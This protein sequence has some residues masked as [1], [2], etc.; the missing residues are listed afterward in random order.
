MII[1][2]S[3]ILH[4]PVSSV[5]NYSPK[6]PCMSLAPTKLNPKLAMASASGTNIPSSFANH[7]G[8]PANFPTLPTGQP[9]KMNDIY[10]AGYPKSGSTWL[11]R[12]VADALDSPAGQPF[13]GFNRD[14][15]A[16][17]KERPG[18]FVVRRGHFI[19]DDE[20]PAAVYKNV[21][22]NSNEA[23]DHKFI[24]IIRDPRDI[25]VSLAFH[26]NET[27]EWAA[28]KLTRGYNNYGIWADYIKSWFNADLC[29]SWVRY[30][31]LLTHPDV[32]LICAFDKLELPVD[33]DQLLI[34]CHRQ[35][36]SERKKYTQQHGNELPRG[37]G[38][39]ERFLRKGI[40]GDYNNHL[41]PKLQEEII[42]ANGGVMTSF[43]YEAN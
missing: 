39:Q 26:M 40:A 21:S 27:M 34:A 9:N 17:G 22:I 42:A 24:F 10:I 7:V 12:L 31:D 35:S 30:E 20:G 6:V 19:I 43:G 2:G 11:T 18:P 29:F 16:E 25:A 41:T 32:E 28:G 4:A 3:I 37:K 23:V 14:W 1:I 5:I 38:F 33:M 15:V 13:E 8:Q 36:F